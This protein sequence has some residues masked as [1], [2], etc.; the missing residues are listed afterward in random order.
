MAKPILQ[1]V[2][3]FDATQDK[4]FT[5][6][7]RGDT[8][9]TCIL[10]IY[11]SSTDVQVYSGTQTIE[12]KRNELLLP[13]NSL[14]NG[15]S[16][17]A[18]LT[19][20]DINNVTSVKSNIVTFNC[21]AKPEFISSLSD[22]TTLSTTTIEIDTQLSGAENDSV[23]II[24]FYLYETDKNGDDEVLLIESEEMLCETDDDLHFRFI[25]LENEHY[26]KAYASCVTTNGFELET[27]KSLVHIVCEQV[28]YGGKCYIETNHINGYVRFSTNFVIIQSTDSYTFSNGLIDLTSKPLIYKEG[29]SLSDDLY[30][31]LRGKGYVETVLQAMDDDENKI[32]V[33]VYYFEE[34]A[35]YKAMLTVTQGI[36][37][38]VIFSNTFNIVADE[39][40]DIR[41]Y[42]INNIYDIQ[43]VQYTKTT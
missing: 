38:Y 28:N 7:W 39:L 21:Y 5:F 24:K 8:I 34:L 18:T 9:K 3:V 19:I 32:E 29:F 17:Y 27:S 36:S 22:N 23:K 37:K 16:Y 4:V 26:Y 30:F 43:V 12:N 2:P 33:S 35:G 15:A 13:A 42:R 25:G 20:L 41:I 14:V 1:S 6:A 31:C 10:N 11:N 40:Y